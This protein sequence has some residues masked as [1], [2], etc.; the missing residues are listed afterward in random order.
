MNCGQ[1]LLVCPTGAI[2]ERSEIPDVWKALG[3]P[4]KVVVVETAPAV[5][6]AIGEEFGMPDGTQATGKMAAAL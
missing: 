3:N 4:D 5:R 1:C 2:T 6:V